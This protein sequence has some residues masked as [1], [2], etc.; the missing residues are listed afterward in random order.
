[1]LRDGRAVGEQ[2][3]RRQSACLGTEAAVP[4]I[5]WDGDKVWVCMLRIYII[6]L[7][8]LCRRVCFVYWVGSLL[9]LGKR[10]S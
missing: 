4:L 6:Q 1:M 9:L 7:C 5:T 8:S 3:G 10:F 2:R